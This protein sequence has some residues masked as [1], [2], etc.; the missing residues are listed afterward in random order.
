MVNNSTN[1]NK[2]NNLSHQTIE[3][4]DKHY[5]WRWKSRTWHKTDTTKW[6]S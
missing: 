2:T 4:K 6:Q 5:I 3:H 1:I